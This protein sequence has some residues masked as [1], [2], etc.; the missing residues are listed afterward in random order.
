MR[1]LSFSGRLENLAK[2]RDFV[3]DAAKSAGFGDLDIYAVEL[4][5]DEA[6]ANIIEHAYGGEGIG[7]IQ[8]TC[9]VN[10]DNLTIILRDFGKP[11]D[12]ESVPEPN[13]NA[14]IE[15]LQ[16][17]GAGLFLMRKMMDEVE[18]KFDPIKGNVLK[19]VKRKEKK[20]TQLGN[21]RSDPHSRI[22]D[23]D[24]QGNIV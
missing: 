15:D 11:F 5:V 23:E 17:G 7:E 2:V 6:C 12:P 8:C 18:F 14:P 13:L 20:K 1:T 3:V 19:L 24:H 22:T 4:A 9:Q 16:P 10:K 21:L